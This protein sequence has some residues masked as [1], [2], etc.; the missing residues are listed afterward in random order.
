MFRLKHIESLPGPPKER[1]ALL[2]LLR[3]SAGR[4][5]VVPATPCPIQNADSIERPGNDPIGR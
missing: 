2:V 1:P 3:K 4:H 5:Q